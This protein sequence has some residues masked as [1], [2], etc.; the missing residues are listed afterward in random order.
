MTDKI[1]AL[2]VLRPG[3]QNLISDPHA[4]GSEVNCKAERVSVSHG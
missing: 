2:A 4:M 3:V 1:R